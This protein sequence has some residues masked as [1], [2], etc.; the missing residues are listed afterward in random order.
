MRPC[1]GQRGNTVSGGGHTLTSELWPYIYTKV[2]N[3]D[4]FVRGSLRS[5]NNSIATKFALYYCL[6]RT[7]ICA[8]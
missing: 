8:M 6:W 4:S 2:S 1:H 5:P 3:E 7:R